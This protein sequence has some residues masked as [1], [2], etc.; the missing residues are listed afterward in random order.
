MKILKK[1]AA[2]RAKPVKRAAIRPPMPE[3]MAAKGLAAFFKIAERWGLKAEE[4]MILLGEPAR[5]TFYNW[6][7]GQ[8]GAIS[9]DT[10]ERLS[11]SAGIYRALRI[12]IPNDDVADAWI[13]QPN[14][15]PIFNKQPPATLML[16]GS[17]AGLYRVRQYLDA[18]RGGWA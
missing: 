7:K 11:Y 4:Q 9:K 13:K 1:T 17:V 12:L 6:K 16:D 8:V 5:S 3:D 10:L 15:A 2:A 18:Q 14:L